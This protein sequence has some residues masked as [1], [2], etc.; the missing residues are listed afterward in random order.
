[1]Y[2]ELASKYLSKARATSGT[3][4]QYFA[5]LCQVCLAKQGAT[6][7]DIGITQQELAGLQ[8]DTSATSAKTKRINLKKQNYEELCCKYLQQC[9]NAQG[10]SRQYYANLC[11]GALAKYGYTCAQIG[12]SDAELKQLQLKGLLESALNYLQEAK[13]C[14]GTKRKC[15]ADLCWEYLAKAKAKPDAIG[16]SEKELQQMC[17]GI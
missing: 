14:N 3:T 5:N 12:T 16:S 11:L 7:S 13:K 9:R 1:M 8:S 15:Y 10:A 6:P 2:L 4:K 17:L